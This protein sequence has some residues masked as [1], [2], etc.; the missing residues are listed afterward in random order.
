MFCETVSLCMKLS[1]RKHEKLYDA[2]FQ[3][4][5]NTLVALVASQYLAS[6]KPAGS[7][8]RFDVINKAFKSALE[9]HFKTV[10]SPM[11]Y[12]GM[13]NISVPY[14]NECVKVIT[15]SSVSH[16]IRNRIVLEAKRLI[17]HSDK[18]IKEIAS[19]LDGIKDFASPSEESIEKLV[20]QFNQNEL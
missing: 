10:K 18:S 12:A 5:C 7:H 14:L 20:K 1:E 9:H 13:L 4:S 11:A 16:H 19:E 6:T 17:Y 8:T 15:G 3:E 2:I